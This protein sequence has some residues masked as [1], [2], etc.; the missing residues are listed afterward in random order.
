MVASA[1]QTYLGSGVVRGLGPALAAKLAAR[2]GEGLE[3]VLARGPERAA[4]EAGLGP[5]VAAALGSW[6]RREARRA[7]PV[8]ELL[9]MGVP[10]AAARRAAARWGADAAARVRRDPYA[11]MALAGVGWATADAVARAA[12][13][14]GMDPRRC[15]AALAAVLR[16]AE[17]EGHCCLPA[18]EWRRRASR[19]VGAPVPEPPA[20]S[21]GR[22]VRDGDWV[23]PPALYR[24]ERDI[25]AQWRRVVTAARPADVG[26]SRGRPWREFEAGDAPLTAAQRQAATWALTEPISVLTGLPGTG[27]TTAVRAAARA[28][29]AAGERVLLLAP[30]GKAAKRLADATGW[31]AS[32]IHRALGWRPG[33]AGAGAAAPLAADLV[34]VDEASMLDVRLAR[35]LLAALPSGA[36]LWLVGDAAQLPP[37]GPGRVFADVIA[38]GGV[39]VTAL[40]EIQRQAAGSPI[41]RLAHEIHH[42]RWP[43]IAA[44]RDDRCRWIEASGEEAARAAAALAVEAARAGVELQVLTA[45]RKGPDGVEALN[46]AIQDAVN[47]GPPGWRGFRPG[48][49]VVATRNRPEVDLVNGEQGVVLEADAARRRL[50][51]EVDG[52]TVEV[53]PALAG[54]IDLA[55]AMTVHKAQGSEWARVAVVLT[56]RQYVL[57][58]RELLYT[59]VTRA[60]RA[61]VV[62]GDEWAYR[63]AAATAREARRGSLLFRRP[64]ADAGGE[65]RDWNDGEGEEDRWSDAGGG[66]Y[67]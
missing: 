47:P 21:S 23:Y 49:R 35:R 28:A 6:W 15:T 11:L 46:R 57:L 36:R 39:P 54:E 10:P 22:W 24:A 61:L 67:G 18:A 13:C 48:D 30:T 2:F 56:R 63:V 42:G 19:L 8:V 5:A 66:A 29:L 16:E 59:A 1:W 25:E 4:Q 14:W 65:G 12:G 9:A 34:V 37:V 51:L 32:T 50:V 20:R 62:I 7:R 44:W 17:A 43:A 40:R 58:S 55:Y 53:P 3:E 64:A 33:D 52:R 60:K 27:K 41:V 45:M 31:P 38:Y 26:G